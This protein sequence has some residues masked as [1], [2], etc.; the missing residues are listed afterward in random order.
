MIT[1]SWRQPH[2]PTAGGVEA[3]NEGNPISLCDNF[4]Y[5]T[6]EE[7]IICKAGRGTVLPPTGPLRE[8]MNQWIPWW[9]VTIEDWLCGQGLI[10]VKDWCRIYQSQSIRSP[11]I[12]SF[13]R[14]VNSR[15]LDATLPSPSHI[16]AVPINAARISSTAVFSIA[17]LGSTTS[18]LLATE[19]LKSNES[20]Y[21]FFPPGYFCS[22]FLQDKSRKPTWQQ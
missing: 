13:L 7:T 8:K 17:K 12:E 5:S 20:L 4:S 11:A 19:T 9:L 10:Y 14:R 16:H 21:L 18:E 6:R 1:E 3:N 22:T 2:N 15:C